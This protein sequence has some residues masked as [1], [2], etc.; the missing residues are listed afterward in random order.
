MINVCLKTTVTVTG[1]ILPRRHCPQVLFSLTIAGTGA[2]VEAALAGPEFKTHLCRQMESAGLAGVT[3]GD[4]VVSHQ[5]GANSKDGN[6][7]CEQ[8]GWEQQGWEQPG[9]VRVHGCM[10]ANS[11]RTQRRAPE[12]ALLCLPAP[13]LSAPLL[14]ALRLP[15]P[16]NHR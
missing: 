6:S 16:L 12:R 5:V 7:G 3:P 4:M 11:A 14:S 13:L 8:Q 9:G 15:S 2:W 1:N 10:G